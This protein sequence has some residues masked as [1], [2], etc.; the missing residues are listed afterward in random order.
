MDNVLPKNDEDAQG[1]EA[2]EVD[3]AEAEEEEEEYE[4]GAQDEEEGAAEEEE[5]ATYETDVQEGMDQTPEEEVKVSSGADIVTASFGE[6]HVEDKS[7]QAANDA[8]RLFISAAESHEAAGEVIYAAIFESAPS[9]QSLFVTPRAVQAM[10]F[11]SSFA[12]AVQ[13]LDDPPK[14]KILVETLGFAHMHLD[15]T[16]PRVVI[17]RDAILD[18]FS[19]EL[20]EK[21]S[22][23]ARDAWT[24]LLNYIG[25]AIIFVKTNYAE[26]INTLLDSWKIATVGKQAH[27]ASKLDDADDGS[28]ATAAKKTIEKKATKSKWYEMNKNKGAEQGAEGLET[29]EK[30]ASGQLSANQVPTT[31]NEMF[32][33]NSAVM[34]FGTAMWMQE[35]LLCFDSIVTNVA[36]PGRLQ[37]ECDVLV[38]R[39][40][41]VAK[42]KVAFSEYKSCMLASLRSLLPKDWSTQHEVAW[43]WLWE[44]VERLIVK[45]MGNPAKW[46]RAL[47]KL[48]GS[49]DE[50]QAFE[51]RRDI[52]NR[53][54]AAAPAG[55]DFFKQSNTYLHFIADRVMQMTLEIYKDPVKMVDDISAVGLRHVGYGIPTE[56]FGPFVTSCVEVLA[57]VTTDA[58]AIE[59][60]RWSL[61]LIAKMTVRTINEGS[62]IVMKA[63]NK[64]N[65]KEL[66]KAISC[67]PRGERAG[68][69]LIVQVGT[70]S[71]S[72]LAW[73]IESGALDAALAVIQDLLTI[74]AD[75]DRYYYGMDDLFKR[76]PDIVQSL[77][78]N[79]PALLPQMLD[80]L[81]WRSRTTDNGLR[82]C[83]YY[84]RHLLVDVN[85][86]FSPTLSWIAK[87][88]DPRLV[89]HPVIV[90][91]SDT[92]WNRLACRSFLFRKSWFFLTL[93]IF[94]GG[95]SILKH[96]QWDDQKAQ[97][98]TVFAFRTFIYLC[99]L[100]QLL[101]THL[102]KTYKAIRNKELIS[103]GDYIKIPKYLA[104]WQD[105]AGLALAIMLLM[106]L[107][108]EPILRCLEQNGG[109]L[110]YQNC[111]DAEGIQFGYSVF[112]MLA[113][114][115]YY[116]LLI[117]LA[118]LSTKVSAYVLVC[119]RMSSEVGLFLLALVAVMLSFSSAISVVK[120]TQ[121]DFA[122]IHKGLLTL[123][124]MTMKMYDGAHFEG[125][126][127]DPLVLVCTFVFLIVI[128][129]FLL[130]MLVAQ[131]TCAYEAV[132]IDMVGYARLERV[133][134]IVGTMPAVSESRWTYFREF[135]KLEDKTEFNAGDVGV[136]GGM[137]IQEPSNAN[138]TTTDM[139]RRFGGS[140]SVEMQWPVDT[141]GAGDDED[142]RFD[143]MEAVIQKT[144]KRMTKGG[145][146]RGGK[147][148][149]MGSTG[150]SGSN[151]NDNA[152]GDKASESAGTGSEQEGNDAENA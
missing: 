12:S 50:N 106:M 73:S 129:V 130:N 43:S 112:S 1:E 78:N 117:D 103:L 84:I 22:N 53:F 115:L 44:N 18:I 87:T 91:L 62:T 9:L 72:P 75:R 149:G 121:N 17:L 94:V 125:Y 86:K 107:I 7:A 15:V 89:C 109:K 126:E 151:S 24:K 142:D 57:S 63:I 25:G 146:G 116:A 49:F 111:E 132:Y 48:L 56:F 66:K 2:A 20:A 114:F 13:S 80:G 58:D 8:W 138:P 128:A 41:K 40:S 140:T 10:K 147:G 131:L 82:R 100:T 88:N 96:V 67:A 69:M 55:Q 74:R 99:G 148:S 51:I 145:G 29:G 30:T 19:V 98:I 93:L 37:E 31:F 152:S 23:T 137:Q 4:G 26:R 76:H 65:S 124:E 5:E 77:A 90:L 6:L 79:A 113:M 127:R 120:H 27:E 139:I 34:G 133:E 52:Y 32:K 68:W 70:Q 54:F 118:V 35:V 134:I 110:F 45:N 135:L 101:W 42:G 92:V 95:Q 14:L 3:E 36:N 122:G 33:F 83:N 119:I 16:I 11:V 102:S 81:L 85:N 59:S 143:R 64:N 38:L 28:G 108:L 47:A 97:R 46:E 39:I 71:I 136:T 60:Y 61:G 144:L 141:E 21:F 105:S 150:Q 123:L 104:S